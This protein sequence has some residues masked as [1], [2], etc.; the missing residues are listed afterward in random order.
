MKKSGYKT[1]VHE[2]DTRKAQPQESVMHTKALF[3]TLEQQVNTRMIGISVPVSW[4]IV[5]E[6]VGQVN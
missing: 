2:A 3:L 5:G 1:Q 6:K 4:K